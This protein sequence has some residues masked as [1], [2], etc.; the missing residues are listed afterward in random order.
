VITPEK[1]YNLNSAPR[2][3]F[4]YGVAKKWTLNASSGVYYKLPVYSVLGF[5]D[6]NNVLA[7]KSAK[8]TRSTHYTSDV[9]FLPNDG[10]RFTVEGFCK[11]YANVAVSARDAISLANLG[12]DFTALGN[13]AVITNGKGKAYG[14]ALF[15][16]KKLTKKF[17]RIL[18]YTYYRSLYSGTCSKLIV[19][20]WD[21]RQLLSD[22]WG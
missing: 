4:S 1:L 13:E 11:Q 21:N 16:Q 7:N 9:E 14:I 8:Y 18:S 17:F 2:I 22:T 10:L 12:T 15:V 3:S 6:N 19:S 5:A 20:S